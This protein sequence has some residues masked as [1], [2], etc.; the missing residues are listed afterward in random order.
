[1]ILQPPR[2]T[3]TFLSATLRADIEAYLKTFSA[4]MVEKGMTYAKQGRVLEFFEEGKPGCFSAVVLGSQ[5]HTCRF[6]TSA[7]GKFTSHCT[8]PIGSGCKHCYAA[9][10]VAVTYA[11]SPEEA[12]KESDGKDDESSLN[13]TPDPEVE[14]PSFESLLAKKL[15]RVLNLL[16]RKVA[17]AVDSIFEERR[18]VSQFS[19]NTLEVLTPKRGYW[20]WG[21]VTIWGTPPRT[22]WECWLYLAHHLRSAKLPV[23]PFLEKVTDWGEVDQAVKEWQRQQEIEKWS[24][25]LGKFSTQDGM[26]AGIELRI[27]VIEEGLQLEWRSEEE[28]EFTSLK[29]NIYDRLLKGVDGRTAEFS[30]RAQYLWR[31]FTSVHEGPAPSF[32]EKE[33]RG[34]LSEILR[35]PEANE[36]VVRPDGQPFEWSPEPLRWDV[37]PAE[38]EEDSYRFRLVNADGGAVPPLLVALDGK[39]NLYVSYETIY[40]A[41]PLAGLPLEN[42]NGFEI[43]APALENSIGLRFLSRSQVAVPP[44]IDKR[45]RRL[46]SEVVFRCSVAPRTGGQD[47]MLVEVTA[48]CGRWKYPVHSFGT[49]SALW[50]L[51]RETSLGEPGEIVEVDETA[52]I[53][54]PGLLEKL[55]LSWDEFSRRFVRSIGKNFAEV[56]AE[57]ARLLPNG[58]ILELDEELATLQQPALEARVALETDAV[59]ADWFDLRVVLQVDDTELS[60]EEIQ[61]LLAARGSFVRLEGKGWRRLHF[62]LS[63]EE[64]AQLAD[65]GLNPHDLSDE[66]QRMHALQLASPSAARFLPEAQVEEVRR[67]IAELQTSVEP[68]IPA[69]I[70]AELRP[71]QVRGFHFLAYLSVNAFGGIL[72][73]DMGL[74][75]TLQTLTWLMW[76][77]EQPGYKPSPVLV[78]C[79][80]SVVGNWISEAER[81]VPGLRVKAWSKSRNLKAKEALAETDLLVVNY[82]QLR[83]LD[84]GLANAQWH[85]V[86]LDEAQYIKNPESQ[87]FRTAVG[88]KATHRVALSGTPIENRLLDLW[89]IMA[90]AMPGVLGKRGRFNKIYG[91]KEDNFARRRL[92]ARVRPFVLR[93]TKKEVADDLP[94]RIEEDL[95]CEMEGSQAALYRAE[96]KHAQQSLL[97]IKTQKQLDKQRFNF[98]TSL[99]RLRQICC[100]PALVDKSLPTADGAK[101][102]SLMELLEPLMEEGQKVLV[103]SQFVEMLE[104]IRAKIT[105]RE[106]P[107]FLLTGATEDRQELVQE[108]Q[109]H[110]GPGIFLISLRAGGSGLNLM[111]A[112]YVVLYDPWWN[113][114]VENQAIDRTHRIGQKNKVIAYRLLAKNTIEEKIRALQVTKR[115]LA[116][117]ILGE[118]AFAQGLTLDDFRFLLE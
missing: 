33:T 87:T 91:Q 57:W 97:K 59:G 74:G 69:T 56:F 93:R 61:L 34:V 76:L 11:L 64:E 32:T 73:D 114:A 113:P 2:L 60:E 72:A 7:A 43:P 22:P 14:A 16:E 29:S 107:Q 106:W 115:T 98:L 40:Q 58:V 39:P 55:R 1:M 85:A 67:C 83:L 42:L 5:A 37:Q 17:K 46:Q 102:N 71:Y 68:P 117:D 75:K 4:A 53:A 80:K 86:I 84:Q 99:L 26:D 44:R 45:L 8:C 96:L 19:Q 51:R 49:E 48:H 52:L 88:L 23:H 70:K 77:R 15:G 89:S 116:E 31:C 18:T 103:F 105:E 66:P 95:Y 35:S 24:Q 112:S 81:F 79:P 92:A 63:E 36:L 28:S 38:T 9:A 12:L 41:P 27:R 82:T 118:E 90:F 20:Q 78:V 47:Q 6:K 109:E 13:E 25:W 104:H 50:H 94:D 21:A 101:I 62:A 100:D 111:S 10:W 3:P 110:A 108:F 30:T 54:L 65:M